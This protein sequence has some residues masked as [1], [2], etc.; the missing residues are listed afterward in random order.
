MTYIYVPKPNFSA[1]TILSW[2]SYN[3]VIIYLLNNLQ[4][5][6]CEHGWKIILFAN[7]TV[8]PVKNCQLQVVGISRIPTHLKTSKILCITK[9][10]Y[11]MSFVTRQHAY[12]MGRKD[13]KCTIMCLIILMSATCR[14][15]PYF[16]YRYHRLRRPCEWKA[17]AV[18][19]ADRTFGRFIFELSHNIMY[20]Y[21]TQYIAQC[22]ILCIL[23]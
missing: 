9:Y 21:C 17:R 3:I 2:Q 23:S 8:C 22:T 5:I 16:G 10:L 7:R 20:R 12:Y 4:A 13:L 15:F 14:V 11:H 18:H 6:V 19:I 1:N